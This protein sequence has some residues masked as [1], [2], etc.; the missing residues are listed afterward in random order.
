MPAGRRR[1]AERPDYPGE[2]DRP[3]WDPSGRDDNPDWDGRPGPA[4]DAD[5]DGRPGPAGDA[6]WD[7]RPGP[8][9]DADWD[10]RPGPA[11]DA[12]WDDRAA[13]DADPGAGHRSAV[14]SRPR[15]AGRRL[16]G[17]AR[18]SGSRSSLDAFGDDTDQDLPPWAGLAIYPAG[19]GRKE[20]R[21]PGAEQAEAAPGRG[22][23]LRGRAAATR[24]RRSKRRL[25]A[26][27]GLAVIVILVV[28]GVTGN[29]P[30]LNS[31]VKSSNDGLVTTFQP[32]DITSAPNACQAVSP[33]TLSQYLPGKRARAVIRSGRS[34]S[35]CTWTL[36]ARPVYRVLEVTTQAF[37]PNLLSTG[38][39]SATFSAIDAYDA[40]LLAMQNPPKA[41]HRPKAQL[42]APGGLGNA[43][44]IALQ[45]WHTGGNTTDFVTVVA[46]K[47]NAL[48]TVTLQGLDH[49]ARGGYGP[50]SVT[51]LQTGALAIAHQVMAGFR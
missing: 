44:F 43:A 47:R 48:L 20:R 32:G 26:L 50:V 15:S 30:F 33:A 41:A 37:A 28:L 46:R 49:A 38:N 45:V 17:R 7:G 6:D 10:G 12:G 11:G 29:L 24:A 39:G 36:D 42:G 34:E 5:W 40:A 25:Y 31:S 16:G 14:Q 4:G 1:R 19:P 13:P 9:G 22:G 3:G 51:T 23:R 27:S 18:S 21:P 2:P 8:A 35:Q